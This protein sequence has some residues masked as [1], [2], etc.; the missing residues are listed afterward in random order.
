MLPVHTRLPAMLFSAAFLVASCSADDSNNS[1]NTANT[2][3][4]MMIDVEQQQG[5][6]SD[7]GQ[8][9]VLETRIDGGPELTEGGSLGAGIHL[10]Q[11]YSWTDSEEAQAD[12]KALPFTDGGDR[13]AFADI[14][15]AEGGTL[16][17]LFA[18]L[19]N[20][21]GVV[22]VDVE[23]IGMTD[24]RMTVLVKSQIEGNC[25]ADSAFATPFRILHVSAATPELQFHEF[26]SP[27]IAAETVFPNDIGNISIDFTNEATARLHWDPPPIADDQTRYAVVDI[28]SELFPMNDSTNELSYTLTN[29]VP[30][31][32]YSRRIVPLDANGNALSQGRSIALMVDAPS[33]AFR[34]R[35]NEEDLERLKV[36]FSGTEAKYCGEIDGNEQNN[37]AASEVLDCISQALEE[38]IAFTADN[39]IRTEGSGLQSL[40]GDD[41]G[42]RWLLGLEFSDV[43]ISNDFAPSTVSGG[44]LIGE[45]CPQPTFL[46]EAGFDR[47]AC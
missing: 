13:S 7:V 31:I 4:P 16:I 43:P 22:D 15:A 26:I 23:S 10:R 3:E 8:I 24:D 30:N 46:M 47:F 14:L 6:N 5:S 2:P 34:G 20:T 11:F 35:A 36:Q 12:L 32:V 41:S 28:G 29:I 17:A 9:T 18:G 33:S 39:I 1:P 44:G 27:C 19:Q 45:I 40:V 42:N 38:G 37:A 21:S 25:T